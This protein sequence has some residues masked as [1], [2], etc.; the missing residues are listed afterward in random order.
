MRDII[1]IAKKELKAFFSDKAILLQMFVLPFIFV[2]RLLYAYVVHIK[3]S[4]RIL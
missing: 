2:F 1:T 3:R 4:E